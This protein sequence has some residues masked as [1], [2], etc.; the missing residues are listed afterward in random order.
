MV[1]QIL[2]WI[3]V[4]QSLF[5]AMLFFFVK[6][7]KSLS[8]QILSTWLVIFAIEFLTI[9]LDRTLGYHHL[10]NPFLI[11]NPLLYFYTR[12]LI[13]PGL[14]LKWYQLWHV[15]PYLFV[16]L[17]AYWYD[18]ELDYT[19]LFNINQETWFNF[20]FGLISIA[21]FLGY[22]TTSL[23]LV[24]RYRVNLQNEFSTISSKITLGWLLVMIIFYMTIILVAYMLGLIRFITH[25]ETFPEVVT[26]AF[27]LLLVYVFSF[28][29]LL[30]DQL[31]VVFSNNH[32]DQYK[33]P[34]L[35]AAALSS[36]VGKL[37]FYFQNEK[38]YLDSELTIYT[39]SDQLNLSRHDLTEVLNNGIGK[40]FYQ[41]VNGYRVE[42]VK[43]KLKDR[44]FNH[45]S[46]DAIGYECGFKSKSSFYEVFKNYTGL[47]PTQ[48]RSS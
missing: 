38:P 44:K 39:L 28:Y 9:A 47:T 32:T 30:Q 46:I 11:F 40:N 27:L 36:A 2:L 24:H 31:Y 22:T 16:K 7:E 45:Y 42:E 23:V 1:M 43:Q 12:S 18:V 29:G 13:Q 21:S 17:G 25:V 37:E 33:N 15:L 26:Y 41:F 4:A 48:Y 34:R 3:G 35:N 14:K 5:S 8:N 6:K 20:V 10:T 19:I